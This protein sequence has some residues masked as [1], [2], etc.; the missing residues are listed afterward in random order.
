[1][2]EAPTKFYNI[3]TYDAAKSAAEK[4]HRLVVIGFKTPSDKKGDAT[5]K[6]PETRCVSIPQLTVS[7]RQETLQDAMQCAFEELQDAVIRS[8]IVAGDASAK[9]KLTVSDD[10]ISFQACAEFSKLSAQSGKLSEEAIQAWFDS[11]IS[12]ALTVA[13]ANAMKF[14]DTLSN[15]QAVTLEK[16]IEQHRELFGKLS[17]PR[18]SMDRKVATSL[19]KA[20]KLSTEEDKVFHILSKKLDSFIN[21]QTVELLGL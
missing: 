10:E 4:D 5:Y 16:A 8:L 18:A 21:P 15:E 13:L 11:R 17:S 19:L 6:K 14:P 9:R 3:N 12:E 1:M 20:V 7:I 2:S